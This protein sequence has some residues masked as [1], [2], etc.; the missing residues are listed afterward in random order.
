MWMF[1]SMVQSKCSY[2]PDIKRCMSWHRSTLD[3]LAILCQTLNSPEYACRSLANPTNVDIFSPPFF[4]C[5]SRFLDKEKE[6]DK[7]STGAYI[8]N[9]IPLKKRK[10]KRDKRRAS[11]NKNVF[12]LFMGAQKLHSAIK[13]ASSVSPP[14]H[15]FY[16]FQSTEHH[17]LPFG[18]SVA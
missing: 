18:I 11:K 15:S 14:R 16:I 6:G 1:S 2:S 13:R 3:Q 4:L 8:S 7:F 12:S 10:E 9:F 5:V 17:S